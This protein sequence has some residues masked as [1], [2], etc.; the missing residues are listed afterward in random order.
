MKVNG[1]L[2]VIPTSGLA[3]RLR[4]ITASIKLARNSGKK[5]IIYWYRNHE[6]YANFEDLFE[7]PQ[8][9]TIR[10]I[11]LKYK[12]WLS[13]TRFSRKIFGF[14]KWY[15]KQFRFDFVFLDYMASLIWHNKMDIEKEVNKANN[16]LICSCQEL[17][18]SEL[19]DYKVF[20]PKAII[21]KEIDQITSKFKPGIIG[22]HIRSTDHADSLKNSPIHLFEEK[23][24]EELSVD[25][26]ASFFLAT[27][28]QSYQKRLV[29]KF[30]SDKILFHSKEFRRD[31]TEGIKDAVVD[32][33]C[34]SKT[35]KI[36]GSYYSSF[37]EVAGRIGQI[38]VDVLKV[39]IST[40]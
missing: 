38:P 16:V 29:Q 36:Y 24:D 1:K 14:D 25:P 22:I 11:P 13:M 5:L 15:L 19:I 7:F 39:K 28:N 21:K 40:P 9:I 30:G 34:L 20:Q 8:N 33:F 3:N 18:Y 12:L 17:N 31:I 26:H 32:L 37:S 4:I 27:D 23:I 10:K 6:L 2:T 35:S